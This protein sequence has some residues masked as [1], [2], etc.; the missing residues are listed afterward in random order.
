MRASSTVRI[1]LA[2]G[3]GATEVVVVVVAPPPLLP[4]RA[5]Y[6][7]RA[8]AAAA[9]SRSTSLSAD[10]RNVGCLDDDDCRRRRRRRRLDDEIAAWW[11]ADGWLNPLANEKIRERMTEAAAATFLDVIVRLLLVQFLS[12]SPLE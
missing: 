9:R 8:L 3:G 10:M 12:P 6:S 1:F 7:S 4:T 2:V 5:S 11:R